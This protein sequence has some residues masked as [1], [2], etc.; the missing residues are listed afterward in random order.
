MPDELRLKMLVGANR[1]VSGM[2]RS[3]RWLRR[4][5]WILLAAPSGSQY[6]TSDNPVF[7]SEGFGL[8]HTDFN[9][10]F[11]LSSSL[12]LYGTWR[13]DLPAG[14]RIASAALVGQI[15]KRTIANATN[16]VFCSYETCTLASLVS[17]PRRSEQTIHHLLTT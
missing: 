16:W 4:M 14:H 15:N 5:K 8:R 13:N 12:A 17:D 9:F 1:P 3:A 6:V 7:F 2:V 10:T 11:P